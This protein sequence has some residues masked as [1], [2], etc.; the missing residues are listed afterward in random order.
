[1]TQ[2]RRLSGR[3]REE[4]RQG[5]IWRE[6]GGERQR[7]RHGQILTE[8]ETARGT[9]TEQ[10]ETERKEGKQREGKPARDESDWEVGRET[11]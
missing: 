7:G 3:Q 5:E 11:G 1:M 2:R 9:K 10:R 8:T 4:P 6:T